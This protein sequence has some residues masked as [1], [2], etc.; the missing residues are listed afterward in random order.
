MS[1]TLPF[2]IFTGCQGR[3]SHAVRNVKL[4]MV[5]A[6]ESFAQSDLV[7]GIMIHIPKNFKKEAAFELRSLKDGPVPASESKGGCAFKA[8]EQGVLFL[9][10]CLFVLFVFFFYGLYM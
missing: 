9:F 8:E 10:V 3:L 1:K 7:A 4:T 5:H 2:R 6:L